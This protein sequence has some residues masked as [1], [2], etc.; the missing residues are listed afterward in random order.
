MP[1]RLSAIVIVALAPDAVATTLPP[2]KF[3]LV[4]LPDVPTIEPSS[5]IVIPAIAPEIDPILI[6]VRPEPS[7]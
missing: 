3:T 7:P 5:R 6:L 4:T 2:T 1:T